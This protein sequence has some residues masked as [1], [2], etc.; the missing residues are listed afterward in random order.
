MLSDEAK[1]KQCR[2]GGR[3]SLGEFEACCGPLCGH[4]RSTGQSREI[5]SG[6]DEEV[7]Y[8]ATELVDNGHCGLAS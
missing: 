5:I 2:V 1:T 7:E 6:A 8:H 4:W 3:D